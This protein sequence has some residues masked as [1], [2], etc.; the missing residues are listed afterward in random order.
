MVKFKGLIYDVKVIG[1]K[2]DYEIVG[3][4][5]MKCVSCGGCVGK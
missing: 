2:L 1:V 3:L 5:V 4:I